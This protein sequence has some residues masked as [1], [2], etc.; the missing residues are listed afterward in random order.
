MNIGI[1]IPSETYLFSP[2]EYNYYFTELLR[3]VIAAA[4]LFDCNIS[5]FHR[6]FQ[7]EKDYLEL[8]GDIEFDGLVVLAPVLQEKGVRE[9]K[10]INKPVILIN[11]RHEGFNYVD[12]DN[13]KGALQALEYL[14]E[15]GHRD[16]A[17]ITGKIETVNARERLDGYKSFMEEKSCFLQD[18]VKYG[19][20]SKDS[21]YN[22]MLGLLEL[23]KC[24]TAVFCANDLMALGAIRAVREKNLDVPEDISVI[25]FDD[26]V[27]SE[28]FTPPLT[29]VRQPLFHIGKEAL[30]TLIGIVNGEKPQPQKIEIETRLIKRESVSRLTR[31]QEEEG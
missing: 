12:V 3:G 31:Q 15:M 27:I 8:S 7:R 9:L 13:R 11:S 6:G 25:G 20:F 26:L 4:S 19:D 5:I 17:F 29:S 16:I 30:I 22:E 23:E 18:Y 28:Y 14:F 24:P 10:E 1:V 2:W 21:G